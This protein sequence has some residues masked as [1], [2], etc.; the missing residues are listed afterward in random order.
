VSYV[1][2][3]VEELDPP[4]CSYCAIER[5]RV[6][7]ATHEVVV[8]GWHGSYAAQGRLLACERHADEAADALRKS[9][10]KL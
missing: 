3:R 6:V 9:I 2:V 4:T 10:G 5:N 7:R 8:E 1:T